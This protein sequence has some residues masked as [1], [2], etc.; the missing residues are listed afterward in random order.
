MSELV[1]P[2]RSESES[3]PLRGLGI[4]GSAHIRVSQPGYRD[5]ECILNADSSCV[6]DSDSPCALTPGPCSPG[7]A[8]LFRLSDI[9]WGQRLG[10]APFRPRCKMQVPASLP[11][12]TGPSAHTG[13][14][15]HECIGTHGAKTSR[16]QRRRALNYAALDYCRIC[17]GLPGRD[18]GPDRSRLSLERARR[19]FCSATTRADSDP[20]GFLGF[21]LNP[22]LSVCCRPRLP[23][24]TTPARAH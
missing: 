2:A 11:G 23:S 6:G 1:E 21:L 17:A 12:R 4:S 15:H 7:T 14:Q 16:V 10:R 19:P 18:C 20:R 9:A 24:V 22:S 13:P 5:S 8:S 3:E